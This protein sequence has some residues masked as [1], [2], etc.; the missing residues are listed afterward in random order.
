MKSGITW[1][2]KRFTVGVFR[3]GSGSSDVLHALLLHRQAPFKILVGHSKGALQIGNAIRSL[4]PDR[5]HGLNV[6]TLGCPIS[7]DVEGVSFYQYLGLFDALGQLNMWGH[8]PDQWTPTWHSTNPMLPPAMAAG[9]YTVDALPARALGIAIAPML[10]A[11]KDRLI[12]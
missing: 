1:K 6:V 8:R 2:T 3:H 12:E 7:T 11:T 4:P 9:K 10:L 5:A